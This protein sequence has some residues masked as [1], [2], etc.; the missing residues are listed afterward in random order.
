MKHTHNP[1]VKD[2]FHR[3]LF[4]RLFTPLSQ[5]ILAHPTP[6]YSSDSFNVD[7]ECVVHL[8]T[9]QTAITAN[10]NM[11]LCNSGEDHIGFFTIKALSNS[12]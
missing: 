1:G 9:K 10:S 6:I 3:R 2:V 7:L 5:Q 4:G 12:D 11:F 8:V